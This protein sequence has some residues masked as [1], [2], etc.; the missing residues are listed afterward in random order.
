MEGKIKSQKIQIVAFTTNEVDLLPNRIL[1]IFIEH[2]PHYIIK[3]N[4]HILAF[5]TILDKQKKSTKI[6]IC[7]LLNLSFEYESI[8]EVDCYIIMIDLLKEDSIRKFLF[9][10]EYIKQFCDL[11]KKIYILGIKKENNENELKIEEFDV[12]N[13]LKKFNFIFG[14]NEFDE[15]KKTNISEYLSGIFCYCLYSKDSRREETEEVED[16]HSCDIY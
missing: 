1:N 12:I 10:L 7:S 9:I 14:Y 13:N 8:K 16:N 4:K 2:N 5:S 15:S 11:T 6:M 3:K